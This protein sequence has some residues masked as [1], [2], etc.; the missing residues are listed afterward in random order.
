[1]TPLGIHMG[2]RAIAAIG[3]GIILDLP[4]L[5]AI[6]REGQDRGA[7]EAFAEL[8]GH[9][10]WTSESWWRQGAAFQAKRCWMVLEAPTKRP[11][12]TGNNHG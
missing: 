10:A 9:Q 3:S 4:H 1:M 7:A 5:S 6:F 8:Q 11:E 12:N 2:L